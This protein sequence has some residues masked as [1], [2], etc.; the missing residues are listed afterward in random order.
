MEAIIKQRFKIVKLLGK[1]GMGEVFLAED[2]N[3]GRKAAIKSIR[4]DALR[5]RDSRARFLHE[6]QAA[7]RLEHPNICAIYEIAEENGREYIVMEYID[8]VNLD[9]LLKMKP[10]SLDNIIEIAAQIADG[11][12][13]AQERNIVH[14]DIKPGNIMI[15]RGGRVK[16]LDFGLAEI[17]ADAGKSEA[18]DELIDRDLTE[19]GVV[20]GTASYISPEQARGLKL[21]GRSDI[22]SFGVVLYEMIENRNPF[23]DDENIVTLYNILH[24]EVRFSGHVPAALRRI[25]LKAMHKDRGQ[26]YN[27]FREIKMDLAALQ[28]DLAPTKI[29]ST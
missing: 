24:R 7:S 27:D 28:A 14:R 12:A 20:L 16:I 2:I 29:T 3:L 19:K 15:D 10:L 25:I 26:R 23:S 6:A 1:G 4:A 8:G 18:Q 9:Q 5:D 21:D 13:A 22:F 11:M 17:G